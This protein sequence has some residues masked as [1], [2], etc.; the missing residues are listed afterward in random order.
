MTTDFSLYTCLERRR[1][2]SVGRPEPSPRSPSQDVP[3][4]AGRIFSGGGYRVPE[5]LPPGAYRRIGS[6][7]APKFWTTSRRRRKSDLLCPAWRL[8]FLTYGIS[9]RIRRALV[10]RILSTPGVVAR[11]EE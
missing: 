4:F 1:R 8:G 2:R 7:R 10:S 5:H 6:P 11:S 9:C 3:G